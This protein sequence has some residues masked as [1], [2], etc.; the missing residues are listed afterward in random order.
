MSTA[1]ANDRLPI[2]DLPTGEQTR[3]VGTLQVLKEATRVA[4]PL[5]GVDISARV[6]DRVASVT[7]KETFRNTYTEHLE[8]V[9][10]FP[11]SGG[12]AVSHFEL[13]VGQRII[14]GLVRE[15]AEARK[16]YAQAISEGKRAALLEQERDD[17]FTVQVGNLPPGEEVTVSLTYSE[18]LPFFEDG[19]TELRLPLVVAPRYIPGN[20]V[21]GSAA[22]EGI[23]P[24]TDLVPD[25]SRITPPR[26][27]PGHDPQVAVSIAVELVVDE[28]SGG[29]AFADL[30]CSQH[31]TR[32]S[33]GS[34][35]VKVELS[36]TDER[37]NRDFV[38]RWRLSGGAVK[39]SLLVHKASDGN[40]YAMLSVLPPRREGYLGAPRDVVFVLDRSG[41]MSGTKITS[42]ARAC[43]ILLSSLGP[44]DRFAILTFDNI[45]E[46]LPL[47]DAGQ[48]ADHFYPVDE[49]GIERGNKGLRQVTARGGTEMESALREALAAI[50]RRTNAEGRVPVVVVLTDGEV[51]DESRILKLIQTDLGDARLFA[52]GIDTAVNSGLLNRVANLGGG[53][54]TFVEPGNQLEDALASVAREIGTP[55]VVD[56]KIENGSVEKDSLAPSRLPDLFAGRAVTAFFKLSDARQVK[57]SGK[58]M[59]GGKFSEQIN[60]REVNLGAIAQLWAKARVSDL[61]DAFRVQPQDQA[62]LRRQIVEI[63]CA[64]GLL[65]RFTAF[66]VVD[67]SEVVNAD[68]SLRKVVQPVEYPDAWEMAKDANAFST[69]GNFPVVMACMKSN[70]SKPMAQSSFTPVFSSSS[71][72]PPAGAAPASMPQ[73]PGW[74]GT[75]RSKQKAEGGFGSFPQQLFDAFGKSRQPRDNEQLKKSIDSFVGVFQKAFEEINSGKM[76]EAG[77]LE[78]A[79]KALMKV[80]SEDEFGTRVPLLQRFLRG[81]AVELI[82]SLKVKGADAG[83]LKPMWERHM[84]ALKQALEEA[85]NELTGSGRADRGDRPFWELSV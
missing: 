53:T 67:E 73:P 77:A 26:L 80:L 68:G 72:P 12:C 58:N 13:R 5:K 52:V 11:L 19:K 78:K 63:A 40:T 62:E 24:D 55:L 33:M 70:V 57:L 45:A 10:I 4:L 59:D 14:K 69:T 15:R 9:Y 61:E 36:R 20:A 37:L 47:G 7:V 56:L 39:S 29:P 46:W 8:A 25:A 32:T 42:A 34:G 27:V 3:S 75:L 83:Q 2:I 48:A 81:Q 50:G 38:L 54:A 60:A 31:A 71:P 28:A 65:T 76:P 21:D 30:A 44:S 41:S 74:G 17:V 16:E 18:R 82:A 6:A 66:V 22:G 1:A 51:G 84:K 64:H 23:E 43:S 49:Q 35:V 79:R 85:S